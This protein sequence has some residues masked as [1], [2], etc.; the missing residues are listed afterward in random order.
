M[1][2]M[3]FLV[4]ESTWQCSCTC[5][6]FIIFSSDSE[7]NSLSFFFSFN[8]CVI[9]LDVVTFI[10]FPVKDNCL[11]YCSCAIYHKNLFGKNQK[12]NLSLERGQIDSI[13]RI[14]YTD[15]WIEGDDKRTSRSIMVQV[16]EICAFC[17]K[18]YFL[19]KLISFWSL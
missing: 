6:S 13:F 14:N 8:S 7:M 3:F 15:P 2:L 18:W 11:F 5:P 4:I 10:L 12:L 1:I 9:Q 16:A 17:L 19:L